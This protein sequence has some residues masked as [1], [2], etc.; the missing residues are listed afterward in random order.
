MPACTFRSKNPLLLASLEESE[1][2]I[3]HKQAEEVA[4]S[5]VKEETIS[6]QLSK[7]LCVDAS[8]GYKY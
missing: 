1:E 8:A 5:S 7:M 2:N 4:C 6:Q 3:C